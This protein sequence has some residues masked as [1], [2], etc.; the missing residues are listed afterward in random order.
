M[1]ALAGGLALPAVGAA[2]VGDIAEFGVTGGS[3]RAFAIGADGNLWMGQYTEVLPTANSLSAHRSP[4]PP[5]PTATC[6]SPRPS[7]PCRL[8]HAP[9]PPVR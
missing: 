5:A 6:G 1:L 4:S 9:P 2:A 7:T 3:P 8:S